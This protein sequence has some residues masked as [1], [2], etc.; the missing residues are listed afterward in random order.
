M[1]LGG[2]ISDSHSAGCAHPFPFYFQV[3]G[4]L[5]VV[6][7]L[8]IEAYEHDLNFGY[9]GE[10]Y[11]LGYILLCCD[12]SNTMCIS[13]MSLQACTLFSIFITLNSH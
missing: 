5:K 11:V 1:G 10:L 4:L 8:E 9:H 12:I 6:L 7:S 2:E 13:Y 3:L